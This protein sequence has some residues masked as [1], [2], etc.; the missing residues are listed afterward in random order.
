L[1]VDGAISSGINV[2]TEAE[3][4]AEDLE[5][6]CDVLT[7]VGGVRRGGD[8][9]AVYEPTIVLGTPGVQKE[10][11]LSLAFAGYVLGEVQGTTPS[12]GYLV[13]EGGEHHRIDLE[14]EYKIVR[15]IVARIRDWSPDSSSEP[16][17]VVLNKHCPYCPFK[18]A[19]T[20]LAEAA[21]DLSLL[22]RM[23]PKAMRRYHNKGIFTVTQL[24]FLFKPRRRRRRALQGS[25][26]FNL[27][28]QALAI[29]TGKIYIQALPEIQKSDVALF[30]DIEGV[31]DRKFSYLIGLLVHDN[32]TA[33]Q[34][35]F[36]AD[37][38]EEEESIW[39]KFL[40]KVCEY[41]KAPI[42][43]YGSYEV[44]VIEYFIKRFGPDSAS[45]AKRLINLNS[46]VFGKVYFPVHSNSLKV[47][48]K[49]L[50]VRWT[51]PDASGLQ[52]L[53]W[54]Y[55]WE[56]QR[57]AAY[58]Q[59]LVSYNAEDCQALRILTDALARL[60]TDADSQINVDYVDQPKRNSTDLGSELHAALDHVRL[61]ASLNYPA[62][63][64][65]FRSD[66]DAPKRKGPG[67]PKG[68]PAYMRTAP[69]GRRTVVRVAPKRTC[70]K[71][72]GERLQESGKAAERI[73][74]DLTFAKTGCRKKVIK[75]LL[76]AMRAVL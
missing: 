47:V 42:Y 5:A 52:S 20:G 40:E 51:E 63:Q 30:L 41:P 53:V 54:R 73:I 39:K 17:P 59:K 22:D 35:S 48:G 72:H 68:H 3:L 76:S 61:Y 71:H 50:G 28:I 31:P 8:N 36:W 27:E 14:P 24:S 15:S 6:Y 33:T 1:Y 49:F 16:P 66:T 64:S 43:H 37:A 45:I 13:T 60:R 29:R 65:W 56:M 21:N 55:R 74:V 19:C 4:K 46:Q 7:K 70:P 11:I 67:A 32:E 75:A 62:G 57:E 69:A 44:R 12:A 2:L 34:Y 18:I 38:A 9:S 10:Q 25:L 58:K 23:S 26:H